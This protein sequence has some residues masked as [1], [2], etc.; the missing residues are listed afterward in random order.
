MTAQNEI[1]PVDVVVLVAAGRG[2]RAGDGIPKQYRSLLG[3]PVMTHTIRALQRGMPGTRILPVIH[4][5]DEELFGKSVVD[6]QNLLPVVYGGKTR[7]ESVLNALAALALSLNN[8]PVR[9]VYIH[10]AARPFVGKK[11][12][13]AMQQSFEGGAAAVVPVLP[14]V[15]SVVRIDE[16][17]NS[18]AVDRA[19]LYAV[20]T[21]QA[22]EFNAIWSAHQAA[23]DNTFTD[24]ASVFQANGG[25]VSYCAGSEHNFKLTTSDDFKKAARFMNSSLTDVRTGGGFD[26]H[27]FDDGDHLWLCGVKIPFNHS[28]KGHSDADVALHALTDAVLASIADGDIGT[29]FPPTDER[30]RGASSDKFLSFAANRVKARGGIISHLSVTIICERPKVGPHMQAMRERIAEITNIDVDRVSVQATT[31]EKLGFTGRGEGIAAQA[32]ATV[33]LPESELI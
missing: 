19:G 4:P 12:V 13:R 9:R 5:D 3:T 24:D 1:E 20:Q 25:K 30:W 31:T 11:L 8:M 6:F 28:L 15:D 22:F 17:N 10:D 32:Q 16:A 18:E 23:T 14:V 29:H 2:S 26:V 27:R 33:R 7:Q 21:P